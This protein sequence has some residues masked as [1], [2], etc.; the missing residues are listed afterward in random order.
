[1]P[2]PSPIPAEPD[3]IQEYLAARAV[4]LLYTLRIDQRDF[5]GYRALFGD[6]VEV[7]YN[8]PLPGPGN[9]RLNS[10]EWVSGAKKTFN[11]IPATQHSVV[12]A[13][14]VMRDNGRRATVTSNCTARHFDPDAGG[15]TS[16][17]QYIRYTHEVEH[18]AGGWVIT[19]A[20]AEI[21]H[22]TGNPMILA[23]GGK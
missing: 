12:P 23:G 3:H 14:V 8:P 4:A 7:D 13:E 11:A 15:D 16:F 10:D 2:M 19:K 21:L 5:E 9:G 18:V 20:G 1:M 22:S 6:T 17:T